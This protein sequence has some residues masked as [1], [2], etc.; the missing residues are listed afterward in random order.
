MEGGCLS[1]SPV[2]LPHPQ[3]CTPMRILI[4]AALFIAPVLFGMTP[5]EFKALYEST[6]KTADTCYRLY[7]AYKDGDGVEQNDTHA[8]KWLLAAHASGMIST[9]KEIAKLP[10]RSKL[11]IKKAIKPASVSDDEA[12]NLGQQVFDMLAS[13]YETNPHDTSLKPQGTPLSK[14]KTKELRKLIQ[15][16]ADLNVIDSSATFPRTALYLACQNMDLPT[17]KLLIE[18]GADPS[19]CSNIAMELSFSREIPTSS[20]VPSKAR[21]KM[22]KAMDKGTSAADQLFNF[23][24]KNGAD[25]GMWTNYGWSMPYVAAFCNS[26]GGI[27]RLSNA[28]ADMDARQNPY[29]CA[30]QKGNASYLNYRKKIGAIGD[31]GNAFNFAAANAEDKVAKALLK[32]G[33]ATDLK[34]HGKTPVESINEALQHS[35]NPD[36]NARYKAIL[37]AVKASQK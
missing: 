3:H 29:E 12:Q 14:V 25:P 10:W 9:R 8:R 11:K 34:Q 35:S 18:S 6:A 19:A 24:I 30:P 33:V 17:A 2:F 1:A 36:F 13:A 16:G 23:L 32:C 27:Q 28:G 4:L 22:K 21:A 26:A 5:D 20:A 7:Q 31:R 15:A 37:D